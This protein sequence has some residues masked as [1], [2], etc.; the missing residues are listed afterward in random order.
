MEKLTLRQTQSP[1]VMIRVMY[2]PESLS[3]QVAARYKSLVGVGE[4]AET[5]VFDHLEY[6]E[7]VV[8][9]I[10]DAARPGV[11]ESVENQ[12][13]QLYKVCMPASDQ[14]GRYR[15]AEL[16][17]SWGRL[18]W[19]GAPVCLAYVTSMR[20]D[21]TLFASSGRPMRAKVELALKIKPLVL[22]K[23]TGAVTAQPTMRKINNL[24]DKLRISG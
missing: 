22:S 20:A 17:V 24:R 8:D 3:F 9:L 6:G 11:Q 14:S 19:F 15:C 23:V 5:Q 18:D 16:Q 1:G 10:L 21:Y 4:T 7:I 12:L 13:A 2:N